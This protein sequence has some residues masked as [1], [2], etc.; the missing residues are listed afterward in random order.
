MSSKNVIALSISHRVWHLR[1][2]PISSSN[3]A[4]LGLKRAARPLPF[5]AIEFATAWLHA[6]RINVALDLSIANIAQNLQVVDRIG[7]AFALRHYMVDLE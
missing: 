3:A 5:P 2:I 7:S 6:W 1:H 4:D